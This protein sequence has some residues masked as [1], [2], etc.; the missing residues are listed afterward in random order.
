[1][2]LDDLR[3]APGSRKRRKRVGRGESSGH[4]KTSC[5]GSKGQKAR[6][7]GQVPP[8]FEGGQMPLQRRLPKRGFKSPFKRVYSLVHVGDLE[9]FEPGSVVDVD[10]LVQCGLV[11]K[12]EDGVKLLSDGELTKA[13][14]VRVHKASQGA[15]QKVQAAGG[16]VEEI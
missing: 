1:M 5:R 9:R 11:R 2:R 6:S 10:T 14:I 13:L 12:L 3:P 15:R 16:T 8:G 4:G 7:G